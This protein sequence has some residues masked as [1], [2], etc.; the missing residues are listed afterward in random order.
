MKL[1]GYV[2]D[3]AGNGIPSASVLISTVSGE[4][5]GAGTMTDENGYFAMY[6]DTDDD[7]S[8]L[9]V[10]SIGYQ[11]QLVKYTAGNTIVLPQKATDLEEVVVVGHKTPKP[12]VAIKKPNY[13][14]PICL[15]SAGIITFGVWVKFHF[16]V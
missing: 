15:G 12:A 9:N 3:A 5:T 4:N 11:N 13:V 1:T 8:Y 16:F 10:S 6:A 7:S 14:L 2:K